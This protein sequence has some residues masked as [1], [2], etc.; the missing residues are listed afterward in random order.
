M[1]ALVKIM[2]NYRKK[3][4]NKQIIKRSKLSLLLFA[5]L[6]I[7]SSLLISCSNS[8]VS[9]DNQSVNDDAAEN[10][11]SET[12]DSF[13]IESIDLSDVQ[14]DTYRNTLA[15][16]DELNHRLGEDIYV[17]KEDYFKYKDVRVSLIGDS[18]A[19]L[20]K[21]HLNRCLRNLVQDSVP[22]R[23][24]EKGI[25]VFDAMKEIDRIGDVMILSLGNNAMRGIET[26]VLEYVYQG[27]EGRPLIIPTIVMPYIGQERNRNRD[28]RHFAETHENC[29]IADWN[30]IARMSDSFITEDGVHPTGDG[31][32]AYAQLMLKTIINIMK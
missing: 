22:G 18:I 27:I 24:M 16:I 20:S 31:S 19:E 3:K 2:I 10:L 7:T 30:K 29:Y 9:E 13:I 32:A 25:E 4:M 28:L 23:E 6:L 21:T 15:K 12:E 14:G 1:R 5:F 11:L 17:T 8:S 26:E